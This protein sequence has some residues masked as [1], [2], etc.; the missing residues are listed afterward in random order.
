MNNSKSKNPGLA[1]VLSLSYSRRWSVLQ[2]HVLERNI[3]VD[4]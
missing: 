1:A 4:T 3:L 2:R